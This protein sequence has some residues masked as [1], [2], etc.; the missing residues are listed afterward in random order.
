MRI[1]RIRVWT[2]GLPGAKSAL[3]ALRQ[4]KS[5]ASAKTQA[6]RARSRKCKNLILAVESRCVIIFI[7]NGGKGN[8]MNEV[9]EQAFFYGDYSALREFWTFCDEDEQDFDLA[10]AE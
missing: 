6:C 1:S 3:F 10:E 8:K 5:L 9:L 2:W 4:C 7:L